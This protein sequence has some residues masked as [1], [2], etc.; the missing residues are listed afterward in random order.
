MNYQHLGIGKQGVYVYNTQNWNGFVE[1]KPAMQFHTN[2]HGNTM[3]FILEPEAIFIHDGHEE[4]RG[5][6]MVLTHK[7][8]PSI[9][10]LVISAG[11]DG[12]LHAWQFNE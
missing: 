9:N 6:G 4:E 1:G 7:W 10:R 5:G 8:H 12:S 11:S 2:Y 3:Y